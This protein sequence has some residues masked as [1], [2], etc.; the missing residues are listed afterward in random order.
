MTKKYN[1]GLEVEF[2]DDWWFP[3]R[4]QGEEKMLL[5]W[6]KDWSEEEAL[7][8]FHETESVVPKETLD[9]INKAHEEYL[10]TRPEKGSK[11]W[12]EPLIPYKPKKQG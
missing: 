1:N 4:Y 6:Q 12:L 9:E 8:Y 2:G 7:K 5:K 11:E 3:Y 10:R